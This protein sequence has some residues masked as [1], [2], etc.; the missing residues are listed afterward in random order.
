[1]GFEKTVEQLGKNINHIK[2]YMLDLELPE[3][4]DGVD[5]IHEVINVLYSNMNDLSKE[6]PKST[7]S[8][9]ENAIINLLNVLLI[10]NIRLLD[11]V[12]Q[13]KHFKEMHKQ[14]NSIIMT[15]LCQVFFNISLNLNNLLQVKK[16]SVLSLPYQ[17]IEN[18]EH[19]KMLYMKKLEE[20]NVELLQQMDSLGLVD[21]AN[22]TKIITWFEVFCSKSELETQSSDYNL[23]YLNLFAI[24]NEILSNFHQT[25]QKMCDLNLNHKQKKELN[26]LF[27]CEDIDLWHSFVDPC[28]EILNCY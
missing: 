4:C 15:N 14:V 12:K 1:M 28:V 2:Q 24:F 21:E 22:L 13:S 25:T 3:C 9:M 26:M 10:S 19:H 17:S 8:K 27:M 16:Y 20:Q 11:L 18:S 5:K 7:E 23:T 6:L